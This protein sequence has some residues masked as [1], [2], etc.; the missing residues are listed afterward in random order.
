MASALDVTSRLF[1]FALASVPATAHDA[2]VRERAMPSELYSACDDAH[3]HDVCFVEHGPE[4]PITY[5]C[6]PDEEG[7]LRPRALTC[8]SGA[9]GD[10]RG[11]LDR[12]V[13]AI[14]GVP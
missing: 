12:R 8:R 3:P 7:P 11:V 14:L 13:T 2:S 5:R 9:L 10:R 1:A 6:L 4:R